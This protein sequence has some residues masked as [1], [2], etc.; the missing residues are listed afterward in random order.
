MSTAG[1]EEGEKRAI[2]HDLITNVMRIKLGGEGGGDWT[3]ECCNV[4]FHCDK[5]SLEK[6]KLFR[7]RKVSCGGGWERERHRCDELGCA[8]LWRSLNR[9]QQ[10]RD[11]AK[12]P[13][14]TQSTC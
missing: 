14:L 9:T 5:I 7:E 3:Y 8:C 4:F 2:L 11:T 12:S 1:Y 10:P 13:R 6:E